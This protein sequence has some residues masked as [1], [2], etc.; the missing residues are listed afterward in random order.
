MRDGF[1]LRVDVERF[2]GGL[3]WTPATDIFHL[4]ANL[5][6]NLGLSDNSIAVDGVTFRACIHPT[7]RARLRE[8]GKKGL[9]LQQP[10]K[11]TYS[12]RNRHGE[13]RDVRSEGFWISNEAGEVIATC[14]R[15]VE[16]DYESDARADR[17]A[18]L[19]LQIVR[20]VAGAEGQT[21]Q[22][23]AEQIQVHLLRQD[24]EMQSQKRTITN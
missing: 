6:Q 4:D 14:Q 23:V 5:A 9:A 16:V 10:V 18:D 15:I 17:V 1:E 13:Y 7:D 24:V 8:I 20:L 11:V 2:D 21:A 12:L 19:A 22:A 3:T